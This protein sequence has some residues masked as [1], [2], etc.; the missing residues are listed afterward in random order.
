MSFAISASSSA[1]ESGRALVTLSVCAPRACSLEDVELPDDFGRERFA[2]LADQQQ[3]RV[4]RDL[5]QPI[6]GLRR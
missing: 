3:D 5:V 4:Q 6:E 2:P 1:F